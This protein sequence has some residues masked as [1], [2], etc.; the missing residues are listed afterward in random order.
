MFIT[1]V[2][3]LPIQV[4][5]L[6]PIARASAAASHSRTIASSKAK[7][8]IY[9]APA[10]LHP[11]EFSPGGLRHPSNRLHPLLMLV[12]LVDG[13]KS[14]PQ[15]IK[16]CSKRFDQNV[17]TFQTK[18]F[19]AQNVWTFQTHNFWSKCL[20]I[21]NQKLETFSK[22]VTKWF[23]LVGD[24]VIHCVNSSSS[25]SSN[26]SRCSS[27]S[28]PMCV[29]LCVYKCVCV[30]VCVCVYVCMCVCVWEAVVGGC[31]CVCVWVRRWVGV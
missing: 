4:F 8:V 28:S 11:L 21:S 14:K 18:I 13:T 19:V 9:S 20:N 5:C 1:C 16:K 30:C 10:L 2:L 17:W 26:R 15:W 25:S 22:I 12:Y 3:L 31:V 29:C 27:S 6:H 7:Q 24:Q 23:T